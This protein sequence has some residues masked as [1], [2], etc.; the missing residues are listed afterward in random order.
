MKKAFIF[1]FILLSGCFH[2]H[3]VYVNNLTNH[4]IGLYRDG[5]Y[6]GEMSSDT[7]IK[8]EHLMHD[9]FG[10]DFPTLFVASTE[11]KVIFSKGI[12]W[13]ELKKQE[14]ALTIIDQGD[15]A[16]KALENFAC[17]IMSPSEDDTI[18]LD[19]TSQDTLIVLTDLG[20]PK[21]QDW[22]ELYKNNLL[23]EDIKKAYETYLNKGDL[24]KFRKELYDKY[25]K[26]L[27]ETK[28]LSFKMWQ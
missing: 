12:S 14:W 13:N 23:N 17:A 15:T 1:L 21:K 4:K 2:I 25:I 22:N 11:E 6:F 19:W 24:N 7:I 28:K 18:N 27:W 26:K 16:T 5:E 8:I 20:A 9:A 3:S 10:K